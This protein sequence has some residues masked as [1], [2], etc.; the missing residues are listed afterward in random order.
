MNTLKYA[1]TVAL[2]PI[3]LVQTTPI[4]AQT[5]NT[6]F[7]GNQGATN[8]APSSTGDDN[9]LIGVNVGENVSSAIR[10]TLIGKDA[11]SK[12]DIESDNTYIGYQA[13]FGTDNLN[14]IDNTFIGAHA[15]YK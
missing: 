10:N 9:T 12:V 4:F 11:G 8:G 3:A 2:I 5:D 15:G 13:R 1:L 14:G 6:T 7:D